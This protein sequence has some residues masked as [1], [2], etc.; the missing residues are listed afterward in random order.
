MVGLHHLLPQ[1]TVILQGLEGTVSGWWDTVADLCST[2][3]M[4]SRN[5]KGSDHHCYASKEE[6]S[7]NEWEHSTGYYHSEETV[8]SVE[9]GRREPFNILKYA[10]FL[11]FCSTSEHVSYD[12]QKYPD[13]YIFFVNLPMFLQPTFS[14]IVVERGLTENNIYL[15]LKFDSISMITFL[16]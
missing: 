6:D 15:Q 16:A 12:C 11:R 14:R 4:N 7:S 10:R 2:L 9:K 1:W 8:H 3:E 5:G 13:C